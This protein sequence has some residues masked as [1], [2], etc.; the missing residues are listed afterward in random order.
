MGEKRYLLNRFVRFFLNKLIRGLKIFTL[1]GFRDQSKAHI[2]GFCSFYFSIFFT[3]GSLIFSIYAYYVPYELSKETVLTKLGS[4]E[5]NGKWSKL[6]NEVDKL[7]D[8][9]DYKDIYYLFK[10]RLAARITQVPK[11][12]PDFYFSRVDLES[13]Y[14]D[15]MLQSR[16]A[17]YLIN[18][19]GDERTDKFKSLAEEMDS[20]KLNYNYY[21]FFV[22]LLSLENYNYQTVLQL[23][24][25]YRTLYEEYRVA[26][27]KFSVST[28]EVG[29]LHIDNKAASEVQSLY[30][31]FSTELLYLSEQENIELLPEDMGITKEQIIQNNEFVINQVQ[32]LLNFSQAPQSFEDLQM[33]LHKVLTQ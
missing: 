3:I 2:I 24:E 15:E 20:N 22:K 16:V 7:K 29:A 25:Q 6:S 13:P 30:L 1:N 31:I 21:Y 23:F 17:N 33:V 10:G 18:F 14:Y 5:S 8:K 4:L 28:T 9:D 11:I 32:L 12:N 27:F 26:D 19:R